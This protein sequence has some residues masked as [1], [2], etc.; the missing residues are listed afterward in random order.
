LRF[1]RH[2]LRYSTMT[3]TVFDLT[4]RLPVELW[5]YGPRDMARGWRAA[6]RRRQNV[7]RL[8]VP[9]IGECIPVRSARCGIQLALLSLGLPPNARIA[10]PLYCCPVVFKAIVAAGMTP[11]FIDLG[12]DSF[13]MS[14]DDLHA[15]RHECD[16]V[17]A[18]HAFGQVCDMPAIVAAGLPVIED[19][20][21]A[22]ASRVDATPAGLFG[23]IAVFSFR[24]GKYLSVGEGGA[25]FTRSPRLQA[26]LQAMVTELRAPTLREE[27][28]HVAKTLFRSALRRRPLWGLIGQ[29]LWSMYGAAADFSVQTPIV[30]SKIFRA[31]LHL[32]GERM[33]CLH[34]IVQQ[35]R[36]NAQ[37]YATHLRSDLCLRQ[38][39]P[40]GHV[41]NRYLYPLLLHTD[42]DRDAAA[43]ALRHRGVSTIAPYRDIARIAATHYRYGGDCPNAEDA[44]QRVLVLP[45]HFM[46]KPKDLQRVAAAFNEAFEGTTTASG[47]G[48]SRAQKASGGV[49]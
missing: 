10:V 42:Q 32:I 43:V 27:S 4:A 28:V 46:L 36:A 19:C 16:A 30:M 45:G 48:A 14:A 9:E 20:A 47:I 41:W 5:D 24:S 6:L 31:D 12:P 33:T 3:Q 44:A 29:P 13:C 21:L 22:L 8:D 34:E 18:V 11:R 1:T 17:I 23:D 35:Q 49:E 7:E 26:K 38:R 37:Y 15:K 25:L 2:P 39:E 40:I